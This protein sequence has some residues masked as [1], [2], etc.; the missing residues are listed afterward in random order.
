MCWAVSQRHLHTFDS[1]TQASLPAISLTTIRMKVTSRNNELAVYSSGSIFHTRSR[2]IL[3]CCF[4]S[5]VAPFDCAVCVCLSFVVR[6]WFVFVNCLDWMLG[7]TMSSPVY[8]ATAQMTAMFTWFQLRITF[9][10]MQIVIETN[11]IQFSK[12]AWPKLKSKLEPQ[13]KVSLKRNPL[14]HLQMSKV[15]LASSK[16]TTPTKSSNPNKY[17]GQKSSFL[18][19]MK[20]KKWLKRIDEGGRQVRG[21]IP[22]IYQSCRSKIHRIDWRVKLSNESQPSTKCNESGGVCKI[23]DKRLLIRYRNF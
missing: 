23:Q 3:K 19:R 11:Y 17:A 2:K 5:T 7:R 4:K 16:H 14:S 21:L 1:L 13:N 20:V 15:H 18:K 6:K 8:T 10:Y 9:S 22:K 12:M